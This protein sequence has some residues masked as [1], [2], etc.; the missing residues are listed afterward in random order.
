MKS[1]LLF[2]FSV[3]SFL[4]VSAQDTLTIQQCRELAL[5]NNK[6]IQWAVKQTQM[7]HFRQKSYKANFFPNIVLTGNGLYSTMEGDLN[8]PGGNLP[9]FST[10]VD[11]KILPTGGFAYFPGAD[12]TYD[13]GTVFMGGIRVEQPLFWGGKIQASYRMAAL[14]KQ[15]AELNE[16]LAA[17]NVVVETDKAY[18]MALK[19]REMANVAQSYHLALMELMSNVQ[20]A[21][22]HGLKSKNDVLKV[23]V[24][25][26]ESK[27]SLRKAENS[28]RL[29]NMN[30]CHWIGKPLTQTLW[31]V[32][33][34]PEVETL[35]KELSHEIVSRPEY[36]LADKKV[37]LSEQQVKLARSEFYPQIGIQGAY[38]YLHGLKV[39]GRTMFTDGSFSVMLNVTIPL[40]HFGERL[41]KVRSAKAQLE[42]S[43]IEHIELNEQMILELTRA[44]NNLEEA[45]LQV[46]LA[47]RSLEL[48]DENRRVSKGEFDAGLES[49][50][51]LLEAQAFWQQAYEEE[52]NAR[53][54]LY[55]NYI[56]YLKAMGKLR[57]R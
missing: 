32:E 4:M 39:N 12:L 51:D 48:A 45:R 37:A 53:F 22:K 43:R 26:N 25:L 44:E 21:Y 19:A 14:G 56:L 42:Q 27:L 2:L 3:I 49:L 52:V 15:M 40:F 11:G 55:M 57:Y 33:E 16:S 31:I 17:L 9:T 47:E 23:Q 10:A 54:Q 18:I 6:R 28:I 46:D 8:L 34:I 30:L 29:A 35:T 24:K 38:N 20:S 41:N 13:I 1:S 7:A 5:N 36:A 50:A